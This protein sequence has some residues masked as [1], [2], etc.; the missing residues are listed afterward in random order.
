MIFIKLNAEIRLVK[1][2]PD[3]ELQACPSQQPI[4]VTVNYQFDNSL[5]ILFPD[6]LILVKSVD[7]M[8]P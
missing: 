2:S 8:F 1:W 4:R 7:M 3:A 5:E 6:A